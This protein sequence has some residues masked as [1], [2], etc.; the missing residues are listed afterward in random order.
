MPTTEDGKIYIFLG[1]AYSATN[2]ELQL[3]HP[4]YWYK[5]GIIRPYTNAAAG[6]SSVAWG[7]ITGTLSDQ[8]DLNTA[9]EA[10]ADTSS[11]A[12]VA[13]SGLY[14]DL[15]GTPTI[16]TVNNATL[17]I[18]KNGTTVNSFTAN[19]SSNVTANITVPTATSD[20]TNDSGFITDAGVTSF[21]GSTGA[22]TYT[23]PVTS[24]N[25]STGEVTVSV[26]TATSDLTNDSGFIT[27][28]DLPTV[29]NATLTIQKNGT[30]V[31]TFTANATSNKTANITVPTKTS[32]L[33]NDSDFVSNTDYATASTGGVVKVGSGLEITNGVLS[34]T[35]GGTADAV[36][37][38][39]VLNKPT[40]ST[41]ATS[42]SY[43][44]LTNK[45]TIPTVNNA[46]LTIQKNSTNVATFTAN[47][48]SN[49]MA[50]ISVPTAT[51]DLTND[52]G[53]ITSITKITNAE[54]DAI[55]GVS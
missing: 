45:P 32:D 40:F 49:V 9:L 35:G 50:N 26:P 46:T 28:S 48:A 27:S 43:N 42:G 14:S 11:L 16:P 6:I 24:V 4:V 12:A 25:G 20:L 37:W 30:N 51:S 7:D 22:V 13:T 41:V 33:T 53:F 39:N 17:T 54:I 47:A 15:T 8:T 29:G 52:S 38:D 18:Q 19:A 21:N 36:E 5:D 23:A 2:I 10:K 44:D 31:Q 34:A 3:D 1:I 55:M